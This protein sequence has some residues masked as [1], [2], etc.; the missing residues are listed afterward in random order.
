MVDKVTEFVDGEL[1]VGVKNVSINEPFFQGHF[2]GRPLM[3]G[4]LMIE[5]MAQ[6]GVVYAK[7]CSQPMSADKLLVFSG[8]ESVRFRRAVEPGDTLRIVI[9][10][11]RRKMG[12]WVMEGKVLVGDEIACEGKLRATEVDYIAS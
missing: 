11:C 9:D 10:K 4:V 8:C 1:L 3:P 2:P 7:I 12:H 5:A 6:V